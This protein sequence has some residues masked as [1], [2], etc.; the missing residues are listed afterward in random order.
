MDKKEKIKKWHQLLY[1]KPIKKSLLDFYLRRDVENI[2]QMLADAQKHYD[3]LHAKDIITI[4]LFGGKPIFRKGREEPLVAQIVRCG[5]H[6]QCS[7]YKLGKC[8]ALSDS[9]EYASIIFKRGYTS[10]A[11]KYREFRNKWEKHEKYSALKNSKN[12]IYVIG[13]DLYI[14]FTNIQLDE[15]N[16]VKSSMDNWFSNK[17]IKIPVKS[18][19]IDLIK[20]IC[21]NEPR[22]H[23]ISGYSKVTNY[24]EEVTEFLIQLKRELPNLYNEFVSKYPKYHKEIDYVGKKALL[25]TINEDIEISIFNGNYYW[26]GETLVFNSGKVTYGILDD[27]SKENDI[28]SFELKPKKDVV[29]TITNNDQVNE[30][31]VFV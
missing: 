21:D 8:K 1:D 17:F 3:E 25:R 11:S 4:S 22:R 14:E 20:S 7:L 24:Q 15:N 5:K 30:N 29:V 26:N 27:F 10:R 23:Y 19:T 16:K 28:I 18:F 2:D 12:N 6:N 13:D 9:C 31:T